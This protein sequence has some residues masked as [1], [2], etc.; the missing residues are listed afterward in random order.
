MKAKVFT[1]TGEVKKE[2]ELPKCFSVKIRE[3]IIDKALRSVLTRQP[4]GSFYLAGKQASASGVQRHARRAYKGIYGMGISRVPRKTMSRRGIRFT[5]V[6]AFISGTRGGREAH[7][8]KT[9]KVW[10]GSVNKKEKKIAFNSL[11]ASTASTKELSKT[12]PRFDFSKLS[13]P[14][15]VE[16]SVADINKAKKMKE[17]LQKILGD[18]KGLV[19]KGEITLVSEKYPKVQYSFIDSIKAEE[20]NIQ[21]LAPTG[22]LVIYTESAIEKLRKK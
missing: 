20:L 5:R 17:F 19:N 9:D 14:L 12:Y 6:G 2:M 16:D 21:N 1:V 22:K 4:Y 8:P 3:D 18:V 15:I 7:P 10:T 11:L 13:L